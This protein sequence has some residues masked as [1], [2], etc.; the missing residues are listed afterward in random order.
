MRLAILAGL[1]SSFA[2]LSAPPP[3][4]TSS[5]EKMPDR[6][7]HTRPSRIGR[8]VS[9]NRHLEDGEEQNVPL[10][11]LLEHG[12]RLFMANWTE[13][14]G[15][16][17]PLT[18]GNGRALSDP[19]S[20]L[21]GHRAFNR[22]SGPDANSCY[23]CHNQPFGVAGGGGDFVTNVFLLGQRFDFATFDPSDK[24]ATRGSVDES[25]THVN[26]STVANQ[27]SSTGMFGSGFIEMLAREMT[28]DLQAVRDTIKLGQTKKLVSKGISFGELT[29]KADGNWD[30]SKVTGLPRASIVAPLPM[31][32]PNLIVRPWH[33]AGNVVSLREFSNTA[34]NQ[35]HGMQTTE[36]F[37]LDTDPDG[38][39]F[40]NE[41]TRADITAISMFQAA[42]AVPGRRIPKEPEIEQ[43][44]LT[45]EDRFAKWGCASCHVPQLALSRSGTTYTEP[46]PYNLPMNTRPGEAQPVSMDLNSQALPQP[47]LQ[48]DKDGITWVAAYTDL[49]L[50]DIAL[51]GPEGTEKLDMNQTTWT[52]RFY[53]GNRRFLTK[54]L[55]GAANEPPYFHHG[56]FTTMREAVLNHFSEADDSRKQFIAATPYE[57]DSLIEFLK[58]LQVL[59]PGTRSTIVDENDQPRAWP[60]ENAAELLTAAAALQR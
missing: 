39:G 41:L 19:G 51:P 8:E 48:A 9:I 36:R 24:I 49:K 15:A 5:A 44:V 16:G 28:A 34:F 32:R 21:T 58:S 2:A 10:A 20:P 46:S 40:T 13:Q 50:H 23:G 4:P 22:V 29:R 52:E 14:E 56:L 27:R 35:H 38:D 30:M 26:L 57:Q 55:W 37:G 47:R 59:P 43:A 54:R 53:Q 31:D 3:S 25:G 11:N 17:R 6:E 7:G 42:M 18:K 1:L 60:P 33:Q 45:G 12:K